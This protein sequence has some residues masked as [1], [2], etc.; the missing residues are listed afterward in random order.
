MHFAA[1]KKKLDSD[2]SWVSVASFHSVT[3]GGRAGQR[4]ALAAHIQRHK[5]HLAVST[6]AAGKVL[7]RQRNLFCVE[8]GESPCWAKQCF[9]FLKKKK[10]FLLSRPKKKAMR[11]ARHTMR[12]TLAPAGEMVSSCS[13]LSCIIYLNFYLPKGFRGAR[14]ACADCMRL[15]VSL[16]VIGWS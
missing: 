3:K 8:G 13:F 7:G 2:Y 10:R 14:L 9:F 1:F 15:L 6:F 12:L 16:D 4:T 11:F 5:P